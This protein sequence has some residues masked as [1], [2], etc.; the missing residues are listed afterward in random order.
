MVS[1]SLGGWFAGGED[2]HH[3]EL[4]SFSK[5]SVVLF[6]SLLPAFL[7]FAKRTWVVPVVWLS[8]FLLGLLSGFE[9][10]G[11]RNRIKSALA[12]GPM[13]PAVFVV[14]QFITSIRTTGWASSAGVDRWRCPAIILQESSGQPSLS[15]NIEA[16]VGDGVLVSGKGE[17]PL[18]GEIRPVALEISFPTQGDLPGMFDYRLFL[19]GRGIKYTG[20]ILDDNQVPAKGVITWSYK[21]ILEPVRSSI[22]EQLRVLFPPP[23]AALVS[24]VLLGAKDDA[25]RAA[26]GP[27][28]DL[29]LAHLFAVSGLHVGILL[30][31]FLIPLK[32]LGVSA[33]HKW[34]SLLLILPFYALL[35]GLPGSVIRAAGLALLATASI[36]FGRVGQPLHFLGLLFWVTTIWR[37]DQVL[38]IGVRLSYCAAAGILAFT[39][40]S[41]TIN[42]PRN[43]WRGFLLGGIFISLAAQWFTLPIAAASFGRISL[44]S[45]LANL[46]AVPTFGV[47]V[48]LVVLALAS[49]FFPVPIGEVL[50]TWAWLLFRGLAGLVKFAGMQTG[51][52]NLGLPVP[53][54]LLVLIW[55]IST[56]FI[57]FQLKKLALGQRG[58]IK[59]VLLIAGTGLFLLGLFSHPVRNTFHPSGPQVWQFNVGQGDCSLVRFPDGYSAMIDTG[60]RFGFSGKNKAGPLSRKVLPWLKRYG[61]GNF[62]AVLLTHDHLDHTGGSA[63]LRL[64]SEVGQWCVAG[65]ALESLLPDTTGLKIQHPLNGEILHQWKDWSLQVFYPLVDLPPGLQENDHSLVVALR[66]NGENQYLWSGDLEKAGEALILGGLGIGGKTRVWKAGHHGSNTSGSQ[67]FLDTIRPELILIS[68]GVGNTY[69]HPSHGPYMVSSDTIPVVRTDLEGSIQLRFED[70]GDIFWKT[71]FRSGHLPAAP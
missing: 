25:S 33:W 8:V 7:G 42:Y 19:A 66:R 58:A 44:V 21:N 48:W 45:P 15:P 3:L 53:T 32:L 36:P 38:D 57:L 71:A 23:E 9:E 61:Q 52:W 69:H 6:S 1:F 18:P 29:G 39:T 50:A 68:C 28:A 70:S 41:R 16:R 31:L 46:L 13:Q 60:G 27:F 4:S 26:S 37:P 47:G 51:G 67:P 22:L 55:I 17:P 54:P 59:T 56:S 63:S 14:H 65:E 12:P 10:G 62:D 24:A 11:T 40:L 43:G 35:T 30:G 34:F 5:Y 64:D 2:G 20:K 49:S